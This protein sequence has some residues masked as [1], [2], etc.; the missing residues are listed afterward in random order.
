MNIVI[1]TVYILRNGGYI[2]SLPYTSQSRD[3]CQQQQGP[4]SSGSGLV[5]SSL[6]CEFDCPTP[7]H[8]QIDVSRLRSIPLSLFHV[9][10][11]NTLVCSY[12]YALYLDTSK[13]STEEEAFIAGQ[14]AHW[15]IVS[16]EGGQKLK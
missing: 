10:T 16:L 5:A 7:K 1:C 13:R 8:R 3:I 12:K 15:V 2:P 6:V 14:G 4:L 11:K 9:K